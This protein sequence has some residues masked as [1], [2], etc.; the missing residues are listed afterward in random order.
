MKRHRKK[1]E[2]PTSHWTTEQ[3][4][5]LIEHSSLTIEELT[6][7]LPY[8]MDEIHE[9]KEILGLVRRKKQLRKFEI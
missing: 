3:D 7:D 9:R 8:S 1:P 4:C 2:F 5:Y 6:N